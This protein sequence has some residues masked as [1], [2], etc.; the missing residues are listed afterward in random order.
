MCF[1]KQMQE[2][3]ALS[4]KS[5]IVKIYSLIISGKY[6]EYGKTEVVPNDP[7]PKFKTKLKVPYNF[8]KN[9]IVIWNYSVS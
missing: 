5:I 9:Q 4:K 3:I 2:S 1:H 8:G 7:N 6:E